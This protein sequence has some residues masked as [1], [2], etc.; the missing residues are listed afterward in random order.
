MVASYPQRVD[1]YQTDPRLPALLGWMALY[2]VHFL[3]HGENIRFTHHVQHDDDEA[4][5]EAAHHLNVLPHMNAG[6]EVWD[7]DRLVHRHRN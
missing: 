6:F 2:R 4:A 5:I 3:D 1:L 7:D